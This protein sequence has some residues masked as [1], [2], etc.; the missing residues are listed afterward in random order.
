VDQRRAR[1]EEGDRLDLEIRLC[2]HRHGRS[3]GRPA[4]PCREPSR[5]A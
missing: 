2:R 4:R 1:D 3:P 5:T